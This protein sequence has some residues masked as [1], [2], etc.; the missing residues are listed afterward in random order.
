MSAP[1]RQIGQARRHLDRFGRWSAPTKAQ[2]QAE[3]DRHRVREGLPSRAE[4]EF[5]KAQEAREIKRTLFTMPTYQEQ[6]SSDPMSGKGSVHEPVEEA[7][8][9]S[10]LEDVIRQLDAAIEGMNQ[11]S[12]KNL[13]DS[14]DKIERGKKGGKE[15][16]FTS[17][18]DGRERNSDG[19][20]GRYV[21]DIFAHSWRDEPTLRWVWIK[22]GAGPGTAEYPASQLDIKRWGWKARTLPRVSHQPSPSSRGEERMVREQPRPN[23]WDNTGGATQKRRF[24][25]DSNNGRRED[26]LRFERDRFFQD[27]RREEGSRE[28]QFN[29]DRLK[30][31]WADKQK[32]RE[33]G[34][35]FLREQSKRRYNDQRGTSYGQGRGFGGGN[36]QNKSVHER[37]SGYKQENLG[38]RLGREDQRFGNK[39]ICFWC[40]QEGHHQATCTN[41]PYCY[42]CKDTGHISTNF[43]KNK[44]CSMQLYGSGVPGQGF[45]SLNIPGL[46][47]Q[48]GKDPIG[49]IEILEGKTLEAKLE[50]KLKQFIDGNWDWK[51]KKMSDKEFL[52]TFPSQL[53]LDTFARGMQLNMR[54]IKVKVTKSDLDPEVSSVLQTGWVKLYDIPAAAKSPEA[55]KLIAELIGEVV[56]ID[57]V[58]LIRPRATRVKINCRNLSNLRGSIEIFIGK[59]R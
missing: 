58:S 37:L 53:I 17:N 32:A 34:E 27:D 21:T 52:V 2:I 44:G 6:S 48:Q 39:G 26:N 54:E 15:E 4:V 9:S 1:F 38:K 3:E 57:E 18:A 41:E 8:H 20:F 28:E 35:R 36:S 29:K 7:D 24:E 16:Q 12:K 56:A 43:P 33:E 11:L 23:R 49:L 45:Y 51:A 31:E 42:R 25:G 46:Q 55:V 40:G 50:N 30:R 5:Q 22:K 13:V 14:G 10:E 19:L 47:M 59:V